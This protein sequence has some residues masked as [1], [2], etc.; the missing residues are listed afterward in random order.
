MKLSLNSKKTFYPRPGV[1]TNTIG[2]NFVLSKKNE[3]ISFTGGGLN[4]TLGFMRDFFNIIK[5]GKAKLLVDGKTSYH[6][7]QKCVDIINRSTDNKFNSLCD[8]ASRLSKS[9]KMFAKRFALDENTQTLT[10]QDDILPKK[11]VSKLLHLVSTFWIDRA[12]NSINKLLKHK[13]SSFLS[14]IYNSKLFTNRREKLEADKIFNALEGLIAKSGIPSLNKVSKA[15]YDAR[16]KSSEV[17]D[18]YGKLLSSLKGHYSTESE[19]AWNRIAT[20]LVSGVFASR[21]FYNITRMHEDSHEDAKKAQKKRFK[22]DLTRTAINT[23][24]LYGTMGVLS[25]HANGKK[26]LAT[27]ILVGTTLITEITARL[28]NKIHILPLTV[29]QAKEIHAKRKGKQPE[30]KDVSFKQDTGRHSKDV[31]VVF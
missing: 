6:V 17:T 10:F 7:S 19:R 9:K 21:D 8:E 30:E 31:F 26:H 28:L 4:K 25:K 27:A 18:M 16:V 24:L 3:Q 1:N 15:G 5:T 23:S 20:G 29:E 2:T 11:I 22:Q 14:R 13:D 12:D